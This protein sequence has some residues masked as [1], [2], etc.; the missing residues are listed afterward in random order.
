M[1]KGIIKGGGSGGE[2]QVEIVMNRTWLDGQISKLEANIT[3][4]NSKLLATESFMARKVIELQIKSCEKKIKLLN[5]TCPEDETVSA[6]CG[7]LTEDITGV[8]STIEVPGESTNIQIRPG[9]EGGSSYEKGRD[10]QLTQTMGQPASGVYYN[11]SML[12]GWQKWKPTYRYAK[13]DSMDENTAEITLS[14]D[15]SSQQN[16]NIDQTT[17]ISDVEIKYMS[18]DGSA[19]S[20]GDEVLVVFENQDWG[21]PKIIGFK[22]NPQSCGE[23]ILVASGDFCFLWDTETNEYYQKAWDNSGEPI[24]DFPV[25]IT[26]LADWMNGKS[27]AGTPLYDLYP[28]RARSPQ[29]EACRIPENEGPCTKVVQ[30]PNNCPDEAGSIAGFNTATFTTEGFIDEWGG[31]GGEELIEWEYP[32]SNLSLIASP[33]NIDL[34]PRSFCIE[35]KITRDFEVWE[36][37]PVY[38]NNTTIVTEYT[39]KNPFGF[40]ETTEIENSNSF[41]QEFDYTLTIEDQKEENVFGSGHIGITGEYS[42]KTIAQL[43]WFS[44]VKTKTEIR[45]CDRWFPEEGDCPWEPATYSE[46]AEPQ[47]QGGVVTCE[48]TGVVDPFGV[49]GSGGFVEAAEKLRGVAEKDAGGPWEDRVYVPG[50]AVTLIG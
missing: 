21:S 29:Y 17:T 6:W 45:P 24:A 22:D 14:G 43:W 7:D 18:C 33:E 4:F 36:A 10:G 35:M 39:F 26:E 3:A 50:F 25:P 11:L 31:V 23:I 2:Y 5:T 38:I 9:Y 12:P 13:I 16:L 44:G 20:E 1:G 15:K 27:G 41:E 48:D 30:E 40:F 49:T 32:V 34:P 19:F 8:V 42:E 46:L 37:P 28:C 47:I